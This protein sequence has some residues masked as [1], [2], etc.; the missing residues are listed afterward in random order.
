VSRQRKTLNDAL[1]CTV[2]FRRQTFAHD[3]LIERT[4]S[5]IELTVSNRMTLVCRHSTHLNGMGPC[6]CA[7]KCWGIVTGA[8]E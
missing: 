7:L 8:I 1:S 4:K 6:E 3:K 2:G 5:Q